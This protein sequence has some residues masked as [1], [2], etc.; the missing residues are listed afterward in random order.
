MLILVYVHSH[1]DILKTNFEDDTWN[2]LAGRT[3][4]LESF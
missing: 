1:Y 3:L 4:L 2:F